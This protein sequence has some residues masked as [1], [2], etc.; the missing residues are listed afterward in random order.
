[1]DNK[2]NH[3]LGFLRKIV[4]WTDVQICIL[5]NEHRNRNEEYHNLERNQ[6]VFLGSVATRI[7]NEVHGSNFLRHH[8]E[9]GEAL[10]LHLPLRKLNESPARN[11]SQALSLPRNEYG[12]DI[13]NLIRG[14]NNTVISPI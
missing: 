5:I 6:D 8:Y 13:G 3:R 2:T 12:D 7:N 14:R 4:D 11:L 10:S 9:V 1:M